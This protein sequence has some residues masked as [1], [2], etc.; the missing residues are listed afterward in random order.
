M[1]NLIKKKNPKEEVNPKEKDENYNAEKVY[2]RV[3]EEPNY[4]IEE[5]PEIEEF[6]PGYRG[7]NVGSIWMLINAM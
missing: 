1:H 7:G 3:K 6:I 4:D 2:T 5:D